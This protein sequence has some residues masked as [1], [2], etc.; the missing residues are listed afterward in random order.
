MVETENCTW[1]KKE[2]ETISHI[3]VNCQYATKIWDM[4]KQLI[5]DKTTNYNEYTIIFN[6]GNLPALSFIILFTK[7]YL[8]KQRCTENKPEQNGYKKY[9]QE[10]YEIEEYNAQITN[11]SD[12]HKRK[13]QNMIEI[14]NENNNAVKM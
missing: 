12:Q 13:W 11:K 2:K 5:N 8:Y 9:F 14:I 10:M 4:V 6:K 7:F 1:C 3:L